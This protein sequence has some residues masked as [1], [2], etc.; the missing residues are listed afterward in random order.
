MNFSNAEL[1]R[2]KAQD[3]VTLSLM[4]LAVQLGYTG[5][6]ADIRLSD[7]LTTFVAKDS[8]FA[9]TSA[10]A[11]FDTRTDTRIELAQREMNVQSLQRA[12]R[13]NLPTLSG[14]GFLG[15]QGLTNDLS[16]LVFYP[17]SYLGVRLSVPISDWFVRT[18]LVQQQ[19]LQLDKNENTLRSLRQTI[20]YELANTQTTLKNSLRAAK[21]QQEN[22]IIAEEIVA[23]TT[24][25]FKQGQATQQDVLNAELTLRET[26]GGYLQALYDFLVAKLDWEKANG[27]L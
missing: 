11:A 26:Q 3:A 24:S 16:K 13:Q 17:L 22:I 7:N 23:T 2:R 8:I 14:Y 27:M 5:N 12:G 15:T 10:D 19:A 6:P 18:P 20:T 21:I 1:Q 4:N 25:R 9:N